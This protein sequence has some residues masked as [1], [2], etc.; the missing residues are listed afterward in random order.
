MNKEYL[1]DSIYIEIDEY[2]SC[3]ILTTENGLQNDPS[4]RIY[5]EDSVTIA[6]IK[7]I[8]KNYRYDWSII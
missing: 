3:I 1:G 5:L 2:G 7:Y 6:L 8:K 4:N